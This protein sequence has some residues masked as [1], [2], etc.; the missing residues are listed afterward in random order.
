MIFKVKVINIFPR[1][2]VGAGRG[3]L[4]FIYNIDLDGRLK[5]VNR[6]IRL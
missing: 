6:G 1:A 2:R 5:T 4:L 3:V